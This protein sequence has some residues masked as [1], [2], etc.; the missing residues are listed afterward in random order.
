VVRGLPSK[1]SAPL[2][3]RVRAAPYF[4]HNLVPAIRQGWISLTH[5]EGVGRSMF[6]DL[7]RLRPQQ[8]VAHSLNA[9]APPLAVVLN[10]TGVLFGAVEENRPGV[11]AHEVM[12]P[13]PQTIRPDM[14]HRLASTLL[15]HSPYLL[16]TDTEGRYLGR[17][18]P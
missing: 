8:L 2:S 1:P 15:R 6:S 18:A 14:T 10:S 9:S 4:V 16:V 5:R 7:P 3:E 11:A 17:Y 13:A 12:N